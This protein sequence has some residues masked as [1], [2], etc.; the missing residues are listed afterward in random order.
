MRVFNVIDKTLILNF[1]DGKNKRSE[2]LKKS[3]SNAMGFV[4]SFLHFRWGWIIDEE[5]GKKNTWGQRNT[6]ESLRLHRKIIYM[7]KESN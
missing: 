5:P 2:H 7:G 1:L 3:Q 6:S 4:W